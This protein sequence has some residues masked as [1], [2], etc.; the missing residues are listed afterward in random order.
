LA[1]PFLNLAAFGTDQVMA[2]RMFCCRS[3]R[4]AAK[5]IIVSNVGIVL[6]LVMLLVG[7]ALWAYFK[8]NPLMP[9]ESRLFAKDANYLLPIFIIR[10]MPVGVRAVVVAA[11]FAAAISTLDGA[12]T[13]LAQTS[14]DQS[15]KR[16]ARIVRR[17]TSRWTAL[18]SSDIAFSK[19]L[20]VA[21]A[22][23]L[24]LMGMA[25]II[26]A[27]QYANA[28]EL[29]FAL[30]GYT[31]GPMLGIF[32]L[33]FLPTR[34]DHTG[35]I[36]AVPMSVL[37]IFGMYQHGVWAN[38]IVWAGVAVF[39]FLALIRSQGSPS[40]VAAI[41]VGAMAIALLHRYQVGTTADREPIYLAFN[42]SYPIGA[43]MTLTLGYLL[44]KRTASRRST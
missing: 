12:L 1:M 42:W 2:Q 34:R 30:V 16:R 11:I 44:G 8:H 6:A 38:W 24:C 9:E 27:R 4:D 25:C 20:V 31:Y 29:A 22:V 28:V 33:A 18:L 43:I 32:L 14:M 7:I 26:I 36:W 3:R 23:V 35:L 13:A 37:M 41:V 40:R 39:L 5:A 21:W 19:A 10:A 15:A 17:G